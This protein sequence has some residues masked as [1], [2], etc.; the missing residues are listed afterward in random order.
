MRSNVNS[1]KIEQL[2]KALG[3]EAQSSGCIYFVGGA[4]ALLIGWRSSTVDIDMR[5]DPEPLGIFEAIA[6]LKQELDINI[7]LASP[8]DFLPQLPGWRDRS[9]F[10]GRHGEI[11]FYHYD[12]TSQALSKMSR[13]YN[14]DIDDVL[15]MYKHELFS[16]DKLRDCFDA[17]AP[18]LIRFP[19]LNP[20]VL[21]NKVEQFIDRCESTLERKKEWN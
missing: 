17:I 5:L 10:I 1:Q 7:E 15:A 14:R 2:M 4:S 3:R 19:A 18:E 16:L 9:I 20:D 8:Q 13:G 6:K 11:W 12:F 21:R